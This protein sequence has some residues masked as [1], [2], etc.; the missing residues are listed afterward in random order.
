[1]GGRRT[2]ET[3][4]LS[5]ANL[6]AVRVRDDA[7]EL[8][9]DELGGGFLDFV[10]LLGL[11]ENDELCPLV[12]DAE[13]EPGHVELEVAEA[14]VVGRAEVL[15]VNACEEGGRRSQDRVEFSWSEGNFSRGDPRRERGRERTSK[16]DALDEIGLG[17]KDGHQGFLGDGLV[18]QVEQLE[19]LEDG[20]RV[21][22]P[23]E[24]RSPSPPPPQADG[25][26]LDHAPNVVGPLG[27]EFPSSLPDALL[28]VPQ[29]TG[30]DLLPLSPRER[31]DGHVGENMGVGGASVDGIDVERAKE[32][33]RESGRGREEV[34][35]SR[36]SD[37]A[38]ILGSARGNQNK[39]HSEGR[40][41]RGRG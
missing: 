23:S 38:A 40:T 7:E 41:R 20:K 2:H 1:M 11:E 9:D 27:D 10:T 15:E 39:R 33:S 29:P 36:S 37:V 3:R 17:F 8:P 31:Q 24:A 19:E 35:Q 4:H 34:E 21:S 32:E 13:G 25:A 5:P 18:L 16:V 28:T 30:D 6:V 22:V 26:N 12:L 14:G